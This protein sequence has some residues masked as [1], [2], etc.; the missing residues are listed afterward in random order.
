MTLSFELR[1]RLLRD[2][3][4]L[5]G[6]GALIFGVGHIAAAF[7]SDWGYVGAGTTRSHVVMGL[8]TLGA[9]LVCSW[10]RMM[11]NGE[12][13]RRDWVRREL[14]ARELG[15]SAEQNLIDTLG[16]QGKTEPKA[17]HV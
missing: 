12:L 16:R 8:V 11:A 13:R 4:A 5:V 15:A 3:S 7:G 10:V 2:F 17:K 9:G 6:V 14:Q 1:L